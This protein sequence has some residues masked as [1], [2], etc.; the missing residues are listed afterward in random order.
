MSEMTALVFEGPGKMA[1]G[2]RPRPTAAAGQV[3]VRVTAAGI[4]GSELTSF[5]GDSKR[6]A[7]GRVFGHELAGTVLAAGPGVGDE[8][9][10]REVTINPLFPCGHCRQCVSGRSNAC[11]TRTLLGMQVDGGFAEEVAV[12]LSALRDRGELDDVAG[13]LVEPLANA[14]HVLE[15]LPAATGRHI[16][17]LGAGAIGL[18][19]I[20]VLRVAGASRITV[21]DP[22]DSRRKI[23]L[24]TGADEALS[25]DD[26][27]GALVADHVV[28]AA[29]T[30]SSRRFGIECCDAGGCLVL[31]GLHTAESE[32]P[33]NAAVARELRLQC[34]YAYTQADFDSALEL[35]Q[36][37]RVRYE[38]WITVRPLD[39]GHEAF[40]ALVERPNE[41]TKIILR[42]E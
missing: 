21:V 16:A 30:T 34:S 11:P 1:I 23:A 26:A 32:L 39:E 20:S 41:V 8:T 14:V 31:L 33:I 18:S 36:G 28:D 4:C 6:R 42:P 12:P 7:P 9:I 13:S 3:V 5:T 40:V 35:L 37:G 15:L 27:A 25:P 2:A 10:G 22:V 24:E 17:V 19:V 29:G 38:P